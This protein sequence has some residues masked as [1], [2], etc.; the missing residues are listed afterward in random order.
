MKK[1]LG[2]IICLVSSFASAM[3]QGNSKVPPRAPRKNTAG[4]AR[5]PAENLGVQADGVGKR[6]RRVINNPDVVKTLF[7]RNK[8]FNFDELLLA[9]ESI[10]DSDQKQDAA[11][12][13]Q[14]Q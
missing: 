11:A 5:K 3:D 14:D 6:E 10:A 13:E 7:K 4:R 9:I 2:I 8:A 1:I 12:A